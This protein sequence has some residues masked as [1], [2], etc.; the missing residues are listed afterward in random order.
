MA[1]NGRDYNNTVSQQV[2]AENIETQ[3]AKLSHL[4]RKIE[5]LSFP[6]AG[7]SSNNHR[8]KELRGSKVYENV[9]ET[10]DDLPVS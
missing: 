4:Q 7:K 2:S 8:F 6:T 10:I 9:V 5:N 1:D 3:D